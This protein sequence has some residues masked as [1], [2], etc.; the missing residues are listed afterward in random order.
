MSNLNETSQGM[1]TAIAFLGRRNAGKSSL[2]NAL[3]GYEKA[4]V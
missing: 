1:R 3:V 4:I 2:L